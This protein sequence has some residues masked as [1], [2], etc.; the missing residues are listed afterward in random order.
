MST[1]KVNGVYITTPKQQSDPGG[2]VPEAPKDGHTYGR[3]DGDWEKI[4][5]GGESHPYLSL[6]RLRKYLYRVTFDS[7]PQDNGGDNLVVGACSSFVSGGKLYRNLDFLYDNAASFIV[8]TKDFEGMSFATGLN[9]GQMDD[10]K[11]ARLPY[12]MV[13]G[14]NNNGIMVAV[15]VLFNDWSWTGAGD[16]SISLTRLPFLVL[17]NVKSMATIATDLSS[18]LGNLKAIDGTDYILQCLVTDGATTYAIIPPTADNQ[19]Y[20]LVDATSYPKMSNFR[21]VAR[22]E[23][24]RYDMDLQTRP[25]GIE[26]FNLMPCALS[27]LRFTK[28]YETADRLSEFIGIDGTTK[29]ST[30]AELTEIYNL[31]R[32]EY[33]A[34]ERDGKTWQT[35]HSVVY[36]NR[37]EQ[38]YIQENW[39]DNC[40]PEVLFA[41]EGISIVG[42][43]IGIDFNLVATNSHVQEIVNEAIEEDEEIVAEA[44]VELDEKVTDLESNLGNKE[45][46]NIIDS[47]TSTTA[48]SEALVV[49]KTYKYMPSAGV[50]TLA[51]T[52]TAPTETDVVKFWRFKFKS[53]ATATEFTPP[54]GLYWANGESLVP[55][56]NT[57]Y[58]VMIDEDYC[59]S[60]LAFKQVTA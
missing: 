44:L 60:V 11:I 58:E 4:Q 55:E 30:D 45:D 13:D 25:T 32:A 53:G 39:D 46:K 24:S 36:G 40:I 21:Y 38:L 23:V 15:H 43:V 51:F 20:E 27:D 29:G 8:R 37:M 12:R 48:V 42:G 31:A 54:S 3:K 9:D 6:E 50:A 28:A 5:G 19:A 14:R 57:I 56:A 22:A 49:G 17:S 16:K 1:K 41:G 34:R 18:V 47:D 33:L 10:D 2:G 26:R 7:L 35:M 52:L 59:V